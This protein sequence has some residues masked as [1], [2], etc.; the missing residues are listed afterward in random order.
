MSNYCMPNQVDAL[1]GSDTFHVFPSA[2]GDRRSASMTL[3]A[4][5]VASTLNSTGAI[6]YAGPTATGFSIASTG[7]ASNWLVITPLAT[8]A[9]GTI[10]L[11]EVSTCTSG[12]ELLVN[13][14]QAVTA[15]TINGNGAT[16]IGAPTTLAANGFFRLKFEPVLKTWY[17]VG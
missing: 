15:L 10:V 3:L 9:A 4:Q 14:T 11:P 12:Q 6:Q 2:Y 16:V 5:Y 17:R 13:S 7:G 8:Y 1:N